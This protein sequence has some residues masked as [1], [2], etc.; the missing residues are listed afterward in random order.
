MAD[1][2]TQLIVDALTRAASERDGLP[3]F[4]GK[5][6]AGKKALGRLISSLN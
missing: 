6:D 3:L 5:S 2:L 1:K 4:A